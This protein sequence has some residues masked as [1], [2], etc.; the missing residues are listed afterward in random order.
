[1]VV[2]IRI[3]G[4]DNNI[5]RWTELYRKF[6]RAIFLTA[7]F[8]FWKT[9][10]W[11]VNLI[12][13]CVS[14]WCFTQNVFIIVITSVTLFIIVQEIL[15]K[16]LLIVLDEYTV[17][18]LDCPWWCRIHPGSFK[19]SCLLSMFNKQNLFPYSLF[20]QVGYSFMDFFF[21][22]LNFF[23]FNVHGMGA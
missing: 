16:F 9:S 7:T 17:L 23:L 5:G 1:M 22:V 10:F 15:L 3:L 2:L 18:T 19:L 21:L 6:I 13:P 14:N 12:M 11:T 8:D 20:F 4:Y